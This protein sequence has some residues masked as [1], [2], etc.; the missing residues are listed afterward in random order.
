MSSSQNHIPLNSNP[1]RL[2][3]TLH[4]RYLLVASV[5][6]SA[7]ASPGAGA[8][9]PGAIRRL[10]GTQLQAQE[11]ESFASKTLQD[12]HVTGTQIAVINDGRVVWTTAY[13]L[14]RKDPEL[15]MTV[16]TTIWGASLTKAVF[17]TYVMQLVER[18]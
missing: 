6:A 11:A 15:P 16:D 1:S 12:L 5:L 3:I 2:G 17:A 18:K 4:F 10:D 9:M 7:L 14:R 13:G 8:Q